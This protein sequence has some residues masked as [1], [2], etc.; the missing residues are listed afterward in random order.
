M[1]ETNISLPLRQNCERL[2]QGPFAFWRG[3]RGRRALI[4]DSTNSSGTNLP[5]SRHSR[6]SGNPFLLYRIPLRSR[7]IPAFAGMTARHMSKRVRF[8]DR[9]EGLCLAEV[10]ENSPPPD[11]SASSRP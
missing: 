5:N 7:W 10:D 11:N 9:A 2:L 1:D 4:L 3:G 8:A 6:E